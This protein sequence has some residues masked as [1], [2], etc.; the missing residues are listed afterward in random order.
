MSLADYREYLQLTLIQPSFAA[1]IMAAYAKADSGNAELLR[2][3]F[4]EITT[5]LQE[6]YD[7]PG[8]LTD[9]ELG[10]FTSESR[11]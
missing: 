7:N 8:G 10:R 9:A 1:L 4:P 5:E 2:A 6:R 11:S 3:T